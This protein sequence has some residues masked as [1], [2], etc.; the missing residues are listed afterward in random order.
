MSVCGVTSAMMS[1][2]GLARLRV[3]HTQ[4]GGGAGAS[5]QCD[6]GNRGE[7]CEHWGLGLTRGGG[8]IRVMERSGTRGGA[9][10]RPLMAGGVEWKMGK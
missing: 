8:D 1:R 4:R 2:G 6:R 7:G 9:D 3:E 10:I 5:D